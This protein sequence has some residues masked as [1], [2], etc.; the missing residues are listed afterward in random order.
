MLR[1]LRRR[2]GITAPQV[3]VR[4]HVPWYLRVI[5]IVVL[6]A[7]LLALAGWVYDTGRLM[8]GFDQSETKDL[9]QANAALEEEVVRLRSLLTTSQSSLQIEQATQRLLSEK[10]S[11]LVDENAR[12]REELAVF[13][14]LTKLE[15]KAEGDI[16]LDR[17]S[18][19]PDA[20]PGRYRFSFL[21][22]LQGPRR[23][24]ETQLS[25]QIIASP[26]APNAGA[27]MSFPRR[28]DPDAA[29]Y[30]I[31]LRNFRRVEGKFEVPADFAVGAVEVRIFEAGVLRTSK[32]LTL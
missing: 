25:L 18:V 7:L 12:L 2:F 8:A 26:R 16:S 10:N 29:Q 32:S 31:A 14:R 30:E 22:A 20:A 6:T 4:V 23:G 11:T 13:E 21:I 19:R 17:L 3:A 24:K 27:K 5:S 28:N 1:R 9:R 15:G